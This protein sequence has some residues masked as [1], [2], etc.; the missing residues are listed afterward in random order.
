MYTQNFMIEVRR[1]NFYLVKDLR[2]EETIEVEAHIIEEISNATGESKD[3]IAILLAQIYCVRKSAH[4]VAREES[5]IKEECLIFSL[6][7]LLL[8]YSAETLADAFEDMKYFEI[9][10]I[11]EAESPATELKKKIWNKRKSQRLMAFGIFGIIEK[12]GKH[13]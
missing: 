4:L 2:T 10:Q 5:M 13:C 8:G 1:K 3:S 12:F 11:L 6:E 7:D 9:K